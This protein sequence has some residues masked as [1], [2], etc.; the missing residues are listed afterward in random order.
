MLVP[1]V[2]RTEADTHDVKKKRTLVLVVVKGW[3]TQILAL[4]VDARVRAR[5]IVV[6]T[7][8]F[9]QGVG[10]CSGLDSATA[11]FWHP[12]QQRYLSESRL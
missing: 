2:E 9:N 12:I 4:V 7:G 11:F 8:D 3:N 1:V 6:A 10:A 5:I